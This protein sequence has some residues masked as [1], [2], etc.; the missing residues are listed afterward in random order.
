MSEH[1]ERI[2]VLENQVEE[3]AKYVRELTDSIL[4]L[5][6]YVM[7]LQRNA[8]NDRKDK[9]SKISYKDYYDFGKSTEKKD[10]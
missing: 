1:C 2:E 8:I 5:Q 3:L 9:P 6:N 10:D 4:S 7:T